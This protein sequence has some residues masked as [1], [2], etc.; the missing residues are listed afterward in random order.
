VFS[1]GLRSSF[2]LIQLLSIEII[3]KTNN[4]FEKFFGLHFNVLLDKFK[5]F[6]IFCFEL[7]SVNILNE[8]LALFETSANLVGQPR[9]NWGST[10]CSWVFRV[11]NDILLHHTPMLMSESEGRMNVL[12][13]QKGRVSIL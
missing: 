5:R 7:I 12:Q 3:L 2:E 11:I 9:S 13:H 4:F 10:S 8:Y 6:F 1:Q